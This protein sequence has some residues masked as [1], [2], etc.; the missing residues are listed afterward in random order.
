MLVAIAVSPP[1]GAP[2]FSCFCKPISR[3][4]TRRPEPFADGRP[5]VLPAND[6]VQGG[7]VAG[8]LVLF[9]LFAAA[10]AYIVVRMQALERLEVW[11]ESF[12]RG[13]VASAAPLGPREPAA[14]PLPFAEGEEVSASADVFCVGGGG[15]H[16]TCK[17]TEPVWPSDGLELGGL[18]YAV[19]SRCLANVKRVPSTDQ[20]GSGTPGSG[21][22]AVLGSS[23]ASFTFP[24]PAP[25][26]AA[27]KTRSRSAA[28]A[29]GPPPGDAAPAPK[30]TADFVTGP[31]SSV[32]SLPWR[33]AEDPV[34]PSRLASGEAGLGAAQPSA[35]SSFKPHGVASRAELFDQGPPARPPPP[36]SRASFTAISPPIALL[37]TSTPVLGALTP[38]RGPGRTGVV[39]PG[40]IVAAAWKSAMPV[41]PS[42]VT[43]S[44]LQPL[45][46]RTDLSVA[47][48]LSMY[49]SGARP[50]CPSF[51][52]AQLQLML[53]WRGAVEESHEKAGGGV[54][55]PKDAYGRRDGEPYSEEKAVAGGQAPLPRQPS[56]S[57][58]QPSSHTTSYA[59]SRLSLAADQALR[60]ATRRPKGTLRGGRPRQASDSRIRILGLHEE[61]FKQ[62]PGAGN[63][64]MT[65][66]HALP[67]QTGAVH[68]QPASSVQGLAAV[69]ARSVQPH[70]RNGRVS[71][72]D[73]MWG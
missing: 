9:L 33:P 30:T 34:L 54:M 41:Q 36:S 53:R 38:A 28:L 6:A 23:R 48:L 70:R 72:E 1:I 59:S 3:A 67:G 52:A 51:L 27:K 50:P 56:A 22:Q 31:M 64:T 19:G 44:P 25:T 58:S 71:D 43:A 35:L 16:A 61:L 63:R 62:D 47:E 40:M 60:V 68:F 69:E 2:K 66:M 29:S 42:T 20:S 24:E 10:A 73:M 32:Q 45:G 46:A 4:R 37:D 11:I 21:L 7:A 15:R 39:T 17:C 18:D 57:P 49:A 65:A 12:S 8:V 13:S 14:E 26:P 55:L 5:F